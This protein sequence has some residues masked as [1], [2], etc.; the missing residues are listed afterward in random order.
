M[1]RSFVEVAAIQRTTEE[2]KNTLTQAKKAVMES[3]MTEKTIRGLCEKAVK[4]E[5]L[6]TIKMNYAK[7]V[8][9]NVEQKKFMTRKKLHHTRTQY[10]KTGEQFRNI[11][12][13][14][15]WY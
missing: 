7:Q 8:L 9:K 6:L 14:F 5:T 10:E 13:F 3:A 4:V 15:G 11:I 12:K 1:K 2:A